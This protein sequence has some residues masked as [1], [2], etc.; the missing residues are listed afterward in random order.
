MYVC[1]YVWSPFVLYSDSVSAA[2]G[3]SF[4]IDMKV[5]RVERL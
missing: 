3:V 4:E 1:M 5:K 2:E